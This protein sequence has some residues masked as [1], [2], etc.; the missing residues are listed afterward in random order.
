MKVFNFSLSICLL[1]TAASCSS[2][3]EMVESEQM[4]LRR[5][6]ACFS[7]A[8][9]EASF[10][11]AVMDMETLVTELVENRKREIMLSDLKN[12]IKKEILRFTDEMYFLP[13]P[14]LSSDDPKRGAWITVEKG[15]V[16]SF[17]STVLFE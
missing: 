14:Y 15:R 3:R 6:A 7:E 17:Q 9:A 13:N 2:N 4:A 12:M 10:D 11:S 16:R 8:N 1:L 5:C